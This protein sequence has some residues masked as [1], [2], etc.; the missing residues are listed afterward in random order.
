MRVRFHNWA[1]APMRFQVLSYTRA[2]LKLAT[3][4]FC[5]A[6]FVSSSL[7]I[8]GAQIDIAG[9]PG[10]HLFGWRVA[11]LPNGNIVV[12]DPDFSVGGV[13]HAGAV[14]LYGPDVTLISKLTGSSEYDGVGTGVTV[15]T[16]G[17]FVVSSPDWSNGSAAEAGA[18][19]WIDGN[20]G[21]NGVVSEGNSL[22]GT[23]AIDEVGGYAVTALANGNYVIA[24]SDW[25]NGTLTHAGAVT[26]A[27]GRTG[28]SGHISPDNSLV[29][30]HSD[31]YLG[32]GSNAVNGVTALVN[33]NYVVSSPNWNYKTTGNFG[34]VTWGNGSSGTHGPISSSNS[35]TGTTP[36]L[37]DVPGPS[38]I[39]R[40][41][42][43]NYVV[44]SGCW[45]DGTTPAIG[46]VTWASGFKPKLG[47][48][49]PNNSLVGAAQNER[50]GALGVTA[51][52]NGNFVV[53][54]PTWKN[55]K[56]AVTW[57]SGT[58][59]VA[60][61]ISA[62]NSLV[63]SVNGDYVGLSAAALSNGHYVVASP[64]WSTSGA[65]NVG[66]VTWAN[67]N[68]GLVGQVSASNSL[69][70]TA[71]MDLVGYDGVTALNNDNYVVASSHWS[72]GAVSHAGAATWLAGA[73]RSSGTVSSADSLIGTSANDNV[74]SGGVTALS[75]GNYVVVSPQWN[76]G[77]TQIAGAATWADGVAG[78]AG[79]VSPDNSLV[80]T[81]TNDSVGSD[82][83]VALTNG[84]FV[85]V[86]HAWSN[87]VGANTWASGTRGRT[88][89][90]SANNSLIGTTVYFGPIV[91]ALSDG[92][93]TLTNTYSSSDAGIAA[94]EI[95]L[96]SGNFGL[97]GTVQPWNSVI[98]MKA[99][100]GSGIVAAYDTSRQRLVVGRPYEN[101]VSLFTMDQIFANNLE[102]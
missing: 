73:S 47:K 53:L 74:G 68:T 23:V 15:L 34:A 56:G 81:T 101:I 57:V 79:S 31:D 62:Q 43:G 41:T 25:N 38:Q 4:W 21:L 85:V 90:V 39:T 97:V 50:L 12:A 91:M 19:T 93:Y 82:G 17:N 77:A 72:G 6:L 28:L 37:S 26:W 13:D 94:G 2:N 14:F 78:L 29:G 10:S 27:N 18:V 7:P 46:A 63:G 67:G 70:G 95:T 3:R 42:N 36:C 88:G 48:V 69:V 55:G 45:T 1:V 20:A 66:A 87:G 60:G 92:N 58:V 24:S 30:T 33:G 54:D 22:V 102:P 99:Y 16:N 40:L 84:N 65:A 61:V 80:G 75:N 35:L 71:A 9:P 89:P 49:S 52:S 51:L 5:A 64:Y 44:E 11:V 59:G 83:V 32:Q 86:S 76:N 98:G 100:A 8:F 96:A